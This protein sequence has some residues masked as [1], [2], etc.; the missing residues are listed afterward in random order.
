MKESSEQS[1]SP[2]KTPPSRDLLSQVFTSSAPSPNPRSL[3]LTS[4]PMRPTSIMDS[5]GL[6]WKDLLS[7]S[8]LVREPLPS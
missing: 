1:L 6:T 8:L 7:N 4:S 3:S 5:D 2:E